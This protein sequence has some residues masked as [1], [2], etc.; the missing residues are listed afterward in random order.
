MDR[1]LFSRRIK[2]ECVGEY[3][4]AHEN[5]WPELVEVY[6]DCGFTNIA[7]FMKSNE[8]FGYCESEDI[9]KAARLAAESHVNRDWQKHMEKLSLEVDQDNAWKEVWTLNKYIEEG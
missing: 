8:V 7:I 1:L 3:I 9:E 4:K 6:K 5:I 2:P